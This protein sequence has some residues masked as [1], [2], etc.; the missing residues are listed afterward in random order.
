MRTVII[1]QGP[2]QRC[3]EKALAEGYRLQSLS[4]DPYVFAEAF[5]ARLAI[6]GAIG[7]RLAAL[8]GCDLKRREELR[9]YATHERRNLNARWN[10]K[11]GK[12]DKFDREEGKIRAAEILAEGFDRHVLLGAAVAEAF[13]FRSVP[14]LE[15]KLRHNDALNKPQWFLIFPHPSGISTWWNEEFNAFRARKRLKE[16]LG[17]DQLIEE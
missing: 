3:W 10:G 4:R 13:G 12:G 9:F 2:N 16:F 6:T 17:V 14:F 5:C 8:A 15:E 1:G 7:K 11:D